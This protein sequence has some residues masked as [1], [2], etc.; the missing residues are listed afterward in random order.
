MKCRGN[1]VILADGKNN[2]CGGRE[3][4]ALLAGKILIA[5]DGAGEILRKIS[6][7]PD[8]ILGDMDTVSEETL[9]FFVNLGVKIMREPDQNFSDLEKAILHCKGENARSIAIVNATSG[10]FD[11]TIANIFF[12]K[13]YH[14][15]GCDMRILDNGAAV[16]YRENSALTIHSEIGCK[17]G[18][19]GA[20][21]CKISSRGLKYE[22]GDFELV[23]GSSESIANEFVQ[24]DVELKIDGQCF[25]TY[26]LR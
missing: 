12:L 26:E 11:H 18:F 3:F 25:F 6:A 13:K 16:A 5:L 14:S 17:C 15:P 24:C 4:E 2:F 20:P 23:L 7:I 8:I 21:R 1:F 9:E 22:L 10:R 19:F